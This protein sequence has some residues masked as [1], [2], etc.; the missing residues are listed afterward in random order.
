[1]AGAEAG[2]GISDAV[3]SW[4]YAA[5]EPSFSYR[6][7]MFGRWTV[8]GNSCMSPRR[9]ED[10]QRWCPSP[11]TSP[12]QQTIWHREPSRRCRFLKLLRQERG[13][14]MRVFCCA[15]FPAH[16]PWTQR[17]GK[18]CSEFPHGLIDSRIVAVRNQPRCYGPPSMVIAT[19]GL[20]R[21]RKP[22]ELPSEVLF[23][24]RTAA[25]DAG[26]ISGRGV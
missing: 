5:N 22:V 24:R 3:S 16:L 6:R 10:G 17:G 1:M 23:G 25:R 14:E 15:G 13:S 4:T 12:C 7:G 18:R 8:R 21:L 9:R 19:A 11:V 26:A 2:A 20:E